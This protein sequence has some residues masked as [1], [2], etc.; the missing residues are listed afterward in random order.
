[1]L[2]LEL[3]LLESVPK[4]SSL[5]L[6]V[7]GERPEFKMEE[8]WIPEQGSERR[9]VVSPPDVR[10]YASRRPDGAVNVTTWWD[11]QAV[12]AMMHML[13]GGSQLYVSFD[14]KEF[15]YNRA[16]A[17]GIEWFTL[18]LWRSNVVGEDSDLF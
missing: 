1:M 11:R 12:M 9:L 5:T 4:V 8:W 6:T 18:G 2:E 16:M 15:Y 7:Y 3:E 17:R 13:L 14:A 10:S